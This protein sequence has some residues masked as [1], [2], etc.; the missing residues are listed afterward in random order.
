M[1][2]FIGMEIDDD[3]SICDERGCR[4]S[5]GRALLVAALLSCVCIVALLA[6][7]TGFQARFVM[8][9]FRAVRHACV[10]VVRAGGVRVD[11]RAQ[12]RSCLGAL[13]EQC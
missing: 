6:V 12:P 7:S 1:R 9:W 5:I 13:C 11:M 8:N 10:D 3:E 2:N 4:R